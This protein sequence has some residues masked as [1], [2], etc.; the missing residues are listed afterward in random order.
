LVMLKTLIK[1]L[2]EFHFKHALRE[3]VRHN[4]PLE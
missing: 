1:E 3:R 4:I 2:Y